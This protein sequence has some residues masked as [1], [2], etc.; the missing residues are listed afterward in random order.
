[1][2]YMIYNTIEEDDFK[3]LHDRINRLL[4]FFET[5]LSKYGFRLTSEADLL[6]ILGLDFVC[7]GDRYNGNIGF[8]FDDKDIGDF[9]FTFY[10]TKSFDDKKKRYF[11]RHDLVV[12]VDLKFIEENYKD[13][14]KKAVGAYD[15][16]KDEDLTRVTAIR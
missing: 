13:L 16:L 15:S 6:D 12:S 1:M 10:M 9:T 7:Y 14:L 8:L 3:E 4:H 2:G 5:Y 11:K